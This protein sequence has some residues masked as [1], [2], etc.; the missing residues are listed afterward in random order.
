MHTW[1]GSLLIIM[2][3]YYCVVN[4]RRKKVGLCLNI[5]KQLVKITSI[6]PTNWQ[7]KIS[8]GK[9]GAEKIVLFKEYMDELVN[10]HWTAPIA[11]WSIH[12]A[13]KAG[14]LNQD[15]ALVRQIN[16]LYYL[17]YLPFTF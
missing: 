6:A 1:F 15:E 16:S 14:I 12:E 7:K 5:A 3:T 4:F 9:I 2:F 10:D 13:L 11:L 17:F 8:G